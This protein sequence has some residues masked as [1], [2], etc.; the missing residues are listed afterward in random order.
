MV[1]ADVLAGASR[2]P[3]F[4]LDSGRKSAPRWP[5]ALQT[6][7]AS[8]SDSRRLPGQQSASITTEWEQS[9]LPHNTCSRSAPDCR[10][11]PKVIFLSASMRQFLPRISISRN[12]AIGID[13]PHGTVRRGL[14]ESV[15]D[16]PTHPARDDAAR[17]ASAASFRGEQRP[18]K[19]GVRIRNGLTKLVANDECLLAWC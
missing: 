6:N 10:I 17:P 8:R 1:A 5:H 2:E 13:L 3:R 18:L 12:M 7:S 14:A 15:C 9:G 11:C 19:D 16:Q 4:P